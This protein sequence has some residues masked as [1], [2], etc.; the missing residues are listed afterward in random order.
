M[1]N[2]CCNSL[3]SGLESQGISSWGSRPCNQILYSECRV[4]IL[5]IVLASP[6]LKSPKELHSSFVDLS[7][8]WRMGSGQMWICSLEQSNIRHL[9]VLLSESLLV[10][11]KHMLRQLRL[12]GKEGNQKAYQKK[13]QLIKPALPFFV[14]G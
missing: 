13:S 7:N 2:V 14:W 10:Y 3:I 12:S 11:K 9:I 5:I 4:Q 6:L 1:L 8:G